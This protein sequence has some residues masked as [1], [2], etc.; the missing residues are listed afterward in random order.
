MRA[1][2]AAENGGNVLADAAQGGFPTAA[3]E[4]RNFAA[5][6][7]EPRRKPR[8]ISAWIR[9]LTAPR[10]GLPLPSVLGTWGGGGGG[11]I[12]SRPTS[13][14]GL[15]SA[16]TLLTTSSD[17]SEYLERQRREEEKE[18]RQQ[19]GRGR[20]RGR[21]RERES[22]LSGLSDEGIDEPRPAAVRGGRR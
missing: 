19:R 15:S 20:G 17:G 7:P 14:A 13:S 4:K 22:V 16:P 6:P 21:A 11:A 9:G 5:F 3:D 2:Y 18:R 10:V 1:A 8:T 12:P